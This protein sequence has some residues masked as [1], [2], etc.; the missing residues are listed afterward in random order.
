MEQ[1]PKTLEKQHSVHFL[2][3]SNIFGEVSG[4]APKVADSYSTPESTA[5]RCPAAASQKSLIKPCLLHEMV[6][7]QCGEVFGLNIIFHTSSCHKRPQDVFHYTIYICV[8]P[9]RYKATYHF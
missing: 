2:L 5:N 7:H 6:G 8:I 1:K 3:P 4:K 9:Y